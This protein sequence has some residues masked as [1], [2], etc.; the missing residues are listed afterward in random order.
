MAI[1]GNPYRL[2]YPALPVSFALGVCR[3]NNSFDIKMVA[4]AGVLGHALSALRLEGAPLLRG[5]VLGPLVKEHLRRALLL[6]RGDP[7]V[8]VERP[9][10][11][12]LLI[13]CVLIVVWTM[14]SALCRS[15]RRAAEAAA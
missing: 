5:F 14:V 13:A 8:F 1:P 4:L 10:S 6:A 3:V 7:V 15:A 12:V 9:I 11:L 2:L